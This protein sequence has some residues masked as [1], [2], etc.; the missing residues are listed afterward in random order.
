[1]SWTAGTAQRFMLVP[2]RLGT[3]SKLLWAL[4]AM[5]RQPRI[6]CRVQLAQPQIGITSN[7]HQSPSPV[8]TTDIV[9]IISRYFKRGPYLY[10]FS[11]RHLRGNGS[12]IPGPRPSA[13]IAARSRIPHGRATRTHRLVTPT[14][15]CNSQFPVTRSLRRSRYMVMFC[16]G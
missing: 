5:R 7:H 16:Q 4:S 13:R 1:L 11:L 12:A 15:I 8:T 6:L 10:Y 2:A 9:T 14:V 3:R